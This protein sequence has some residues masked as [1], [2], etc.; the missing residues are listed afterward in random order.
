MATARR[1]YAFLARRRVPVHALALSAVPL[2]PLPL[3]EELARYLV[4]TP[5]Y[6]RSWRAR[7]RANPNPKP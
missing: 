5:S 1:V 3:H 7:A 2:V 6:T 4:I